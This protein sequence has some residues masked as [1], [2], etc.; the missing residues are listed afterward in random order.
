MT[1]FDTDELALKKFAGLRMHAPIPD[2]G[3]RPPEHLPDLTDARA[4]AFDTETKDPELEQAGPGWGRG[5]GKGHIVGVGVCALARSGERWRAYLP[6]RHE[7][8]PET[9]MDPAAVF[10]WLKQQL[11]T[12]HIPKV[13]ANLLYD[14]GWLTTEDIYVEG[15][16]HDVQF[17]EALI[18]DTAFVALDILA[19]KYLGEKKETDL[20][21]DWIRQSYKPG[22]GKERA[23]IYKTP[24]RLVGPYGEQDADLPIRIIDCQYPLI[25][26]NGLSYVYKL[27]H[28]LIR[29]LVKM[30][31]RGVRV[32]LRKAEQLVH[33]LKGRIGQLYKKFADQYGVAVS[34][35]GSS[36]QLAK[37]F[38]KEGV[39]Y[40]KTEKGSA[41]FR[42]EWLDALEHPLGDSIN[43]I[44]K[45]EK[46]VGT[47][48][49]GYILEKSIPDGSGRYG[50]LHGSLHPLKDDDNGAKTGRFASSDPNLQNIPIRT[51]EGKLIREAFVPHEG[52]IAWEKDDYSQIEYRMLAHY[53]V[54]NG[55]GS[56]ERL[57]QSYR[58]DPKT[59]YHL[60]V[61]GNVKTLTGIEIPRRPIKNINFGLVYGQSQK[62]LAYK[63]GFTKQEAD[64]VFNAYHK[65]AP[66]VK[67]TLRAI[68][69]E[70]QREGCIRT[71]INRRVSFPLWEPNYK[72][73]K[74]GEER[75]TPLPFHMAVREYGSN[76]KRAG[77]YKGVNYKL[78]GSG[79]GDVIK[80]AMREC[81]QSGVF[82]FIG[83]P[84]LQVHDELDFSVYDDSPQQQEAYKYM[85]HTLANS[86]RCS[87][88]ILVDSKRG[89]HWGA[90]D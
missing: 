56:A 65:G 50:V 75:P 49:E 51:D 37:V 46:C 82:D 76:I 4:I 83:V 1:L 42:K 38:D 39:S 27:E 68:A 5:P 62:S 53:A 32:D 59:D 58:D 84:M 52:C 63:A 74:P 18:D 67:P 61:Q 81:D 55:D 44:R 57:R 22:K 90:I 20:L 12:R 26:Q 35:M 2:T 54:D 29:L 78:Q 34:S 48:L 80:V 88:P 60:Y 30:R 72:V 64:A 17:A 87:V 19:K 8:E 79:T 33:T 25:E 89:E 73:G 40:P 69:E 31:L 36:Q 7:V 11:E 86:M 21:Y 15:D 41:S 10:R 45:L 3:W 28:D 47:F 66:Y 43:E 9:N 6:V 14:V 77:D 13:G 16:L 85:R 71:I 24:P 70:V 23:F